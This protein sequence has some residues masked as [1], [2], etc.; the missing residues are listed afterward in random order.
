MNYCLSTLFGSLSSPRNSN[1]EQAGDIGNKS[2]PSS[3]STVTSIIEEDRFPSTPRESC[4]AQSSLHFGVHDIFFA[5]GNFAKSRLGNIN[6]S[7][8]CSQHQ[9]KYN[10]ALKGQQ[11]KYDDTNVVYKASVLR[12]IVAEFKQQYPESKIWT[13]KND[14]SSGWLD[15]TDDMNAIISKLQYKLCR[16]LPVKSD[17]LKRTASEAHDNLRLVASKQS[18]CDISPSAGEK[19]SASKPCSPC[20]GFPITMSPVSAAS[21]QNKCNLSPCEDSAIL[22]RVIIDLQREKDTL[23]KKI[24]ALEKDF[25]LLKSNVTNSALQQEQED[26]DDVIKSQLMSYG[27]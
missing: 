1:V 22:F 4:G 8:I 19:I 25:L 7:R 2:Y 27:Q 12:E 3:L 5:S 21:D 11:R 20:A 24:N 26:R 17:K 15:I 10:T 14:S 23:L 16:K 9:E 18:K 6:L 13:R